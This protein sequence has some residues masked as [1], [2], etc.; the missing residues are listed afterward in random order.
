[1]TARELLTYTMS[2]LN[3]QECPPLLLEDYNYF[4]NKALFEYVRDITNFNDMTQELSD[5]LRVLSGTAYIS[6]F[7]KKTTFGLDS[8]S[9][10][11]ELPAD[12]LRINNC[13]AEIKVLKSVGC[14]VVND[15]LYVPVKRGTADKF[16]GM[17][18]NYYLKPSYKT[19]YY[20]IHKESNYTLNDVKDKDKLAGS[21][22]GNPSSVSL[23]IR[24]GSSS[25]TYSLNK[26]AVDYL[27]V[28]RFI[29]ITQSQIDSEADTTQIIEFPDS[30]CFEIIKKLTMMLL[31]NAGDPRAGSNVAVNQTNQIGVPDGIV[32]QS[33]N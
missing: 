10:I 16:S 21:Q 7:S 31:E 23:E 18:R 2:E 11:A 9:Y 12:Y 3:K 17:V 6:T 5:S 15:L 24:C 26:I 22:I 25:G 29:K 8:E 28:P 33:K 4:I 20:Y 27:R 19:P 32:N 14:N 13:I 1:M 30:V